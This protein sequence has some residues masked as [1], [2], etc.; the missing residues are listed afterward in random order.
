MGKLLD[1]LN[2]QLK[3][4]YKEDAENCIKI[5]NHLKEKTDHIWESDW[6]PLVNTSFIGD[7]PNSKRISKP[8]NIGNVFLNGLNNKK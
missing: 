8:T 3:S 4:D 7:Y 2:R 1:S 6:N 5:Y